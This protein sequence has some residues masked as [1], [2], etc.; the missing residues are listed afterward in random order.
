[1]SEFKDFLKEYKIIPMAIAFIMATAATTVVQS[2]V[3]NLIMPLVT[4]FIPDG[5]WQTANLTLGPIV[6]GMGALIGALMNFIIIALVIFFI[7]KVFF[8]EEKVEKK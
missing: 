8:K 4:P 5:A 3:N 2:I 7:A 1:M 6:I